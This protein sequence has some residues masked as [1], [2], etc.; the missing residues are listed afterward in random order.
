MVKV[1]YIPYSEIIVHEALEHDSQ[2]FFEEVV[3]QTLASGVH[4]EPS[5]NW[6]DGLAFV[7]VPMPPTEDVIRENLVGKVHYAAVG[8]ARTDFQTQATVR[9]GSQTYNVRMRKADNNPAMVDL[10]KFLKSLKS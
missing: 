4:V 6:I 5:V 10:V 8:F 9:I 1:T 3:R 7:I 2:T